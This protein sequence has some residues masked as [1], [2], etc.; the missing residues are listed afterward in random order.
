MEKSLIKTA[1]KVGLKI[2]EEKMEYLVV[3][4]ENRNWVQKKVIE[5]EE[6]RF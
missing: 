6:Y 5:V 4:R 1:E 3:S 2:N